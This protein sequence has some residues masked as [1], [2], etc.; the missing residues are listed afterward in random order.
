MTKYQFKIR[1]RGGMIV[2]NLTIAGKDQP[3]AERKLMQMYQGCEVIDAITLGDQGR[4]ETADM[5]KILALISRQDRDA[6][7]V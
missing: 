3:D 1:A 6:G 2:E 7:P 4:Q 5:D